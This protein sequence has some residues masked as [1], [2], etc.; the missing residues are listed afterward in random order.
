MSPVSWIIL[1]VIAAVIVAA[2]VFLV[3]KNY[4]KVGPNEVLIISGG[5]QKTVTEPDGT[6]RMVGYRMRIG[7]GTFVKPFIESAQ[8]LPIEIL[9]VNIKTS[10]VLTNSGIGISCEGQAQ[11]KVGSEEWL[12][13]RAAEQFLGKGAEGMKDISRQVIEGYMRGLI[14]S[15]SVEEVYQKREEFSNRL[16]E[17]CKTD[18][19]RMGLEVV[20]FALKDITDEQ[21]YIE[22]LGKPR[23]AKVKADASVAQA[24]A[25]K[26]ATIKAAIARKEG[27]I[28]KYQ[29]ETEI[30][31]ANQEYEIKRAEFLSNV[32]QKKAKADIAY[33]LERHRQNQEMKR[34]ELATRL[35]EKESG[36]KV[37]EAE[38]K[39]KELE[40]EATVKKLA[41][42]DKYRMQIEAEAQNFKIT[43]EAK[44]SAESIRLQGEAEAESMRKRA[45]AYKEFNEAATYKMF[46]DILPEL[47]RSVSEPLSKVEKIIMVG[48]GAGG[49]SKLTGQVANIM[50]QLPDVVESLSGVDM[51][52]MLKKIRKESEKEEK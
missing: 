31:A 8:V 34:E 3:A 32:N 25:D 51:K 50:A 39:R 48:D 15:M 46:I 28:A 52:K 40:L 17:G 29:A 47:A 4:R 14:G 27:D 18:F 33:D 11:I 13:R 1:I 9:T 12:I 45:D 21:G 24:E 41:E 23:I 19:Q 36:I 30:A 22:A 16:K 20:S 37:E 6:T 10:D 7:G 42:A 43:Q 5:K 35:V 49:A 26:D 44:A 38:I 2:V